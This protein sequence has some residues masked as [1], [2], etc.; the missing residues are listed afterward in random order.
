MRTALRQTRSTRSS[1]SAP[2]APST[3]AADRATAYARAVVAGEIA[4][5]R[6]VRL[7]CERHLRDLE[8]AAA[9]GFVWSSWHADRAINFFRFLHHGKG[10]KGG[11]VIDLEPWQCF[12]VG[13]VFGWLRAATGLRRFRRATVVVAKKNGKSTMLGGIGL[14]GLLGDRE[15]GAE[16]YTA[17]TTKDQARQVFD[18]ADF[19]VKCSPLMM[20]RLDRLKSAIVDRQFSSSFKPLSADS[21]TADGINPHMA[22]VDELHRHKT[23]AMLDLLSD[24]M[25]ARSQPLLWVITTAGDDRPTTPYATEEDYAIKVLEGTLTDDTYFAYL[26]MLDPGDDWTDEKNWIKANPNLGVSVDLENLRSAAEKAKGTPDAQS[27]FKRLRLN[28]RTAAATRGVEMADWN[29]LAPMRVKPAPVEIRS[30]RRCWGALDAASKTDLAAWLRLYEPCD[31]DPKW[32]LE[33][34]FWVPGDKLLERE[35]RDRARYRD[36][37]AQGW[38]EATEG[39]LIDHEAIKRA[40]V[41]GHKESPL[42]R[43]AFDPWN[44]TMLSQAVA[45]EGVSIVE[46]PQTLRSYAAGVAEFEARLAARDLDHGGN[47]VLAWMASNLHWWKDGKENKMPH[48]G[49][50]TGRIDG[51]TALLMCHALAVTPGDGD[52]PFEFTGL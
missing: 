43:L 24:S 32:R 9:R 37:V 27:G 47:P 8:T 26:A 51:M 21:N 7:A 15:H 40:I 6:L 34:R 29:A 52:K 50:S 25:D 17:A 46:F 10:A 11:N 30:G 49:S 14:Y 39:N 23:R 20:N 42:E 35:K 19:M 48:K 33:A 16:I 1:P 4:T 38:I 36:W 5:G 12:I 3:D 28:I 31:A 41:E 13:G 22:I 45:A 2:P 44:A 18:A